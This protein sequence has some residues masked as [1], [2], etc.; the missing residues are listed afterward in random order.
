MEREEGV[1]VRGRVE[2]DMRQPFRS[3]KEAVML[4]GEKVLAGEIH[5]KQLKE[6]KA[7]GG[8]NQPK[9]GGE[10]REELEETKQSLQKA[11]E[12]GTFMAHCLQSLKEEL[13]LTRREIQQLKTREPQHK[14]PLVMM[15]PEIEELKFIEQPSSKVEVKTQ[16]VEQDDDDEKEEEIEFQKKRSVKFAS[17]PL[18]TKV[19]AVNKED[20]KKE[21]ETSPSQLKKKLKRKPLI[22]LIGALFSKKKGNQE[23]A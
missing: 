5:A 14:V 23:N 4:F 20:V 15:D 9:F 22:P 13:E 8:K 18:L 7:S 16:T 12:E 11:K 3:V 17:P 21:C 2:I 1:V 19:I 6:T 10:V